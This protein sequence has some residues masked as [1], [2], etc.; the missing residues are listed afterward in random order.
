MYTPNVAILICLT[1]N[2]FYYTKG[3]RLNFWGYFFLL[4]YDWNAAIPLAKAKKYDYTIEHISLFL[5]NEDALKLTY[6][7]LIQFLLKVAMKH[8]SCLTLLEQ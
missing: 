3:R 5:K 8:A 2:Y 7:Q 1:D 4:G 6:P